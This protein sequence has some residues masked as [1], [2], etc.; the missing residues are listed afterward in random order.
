MARLGEAAR[1]NCLPCQDRQTNIP[2]AVTVLRV[3]ASKRTRL[4]PLMKPRAI[5]RGRRRESTR[6]D[7]LILMGNLVAEEGLELPTRGL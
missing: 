6:R 7:R 1:A 5:S 3:T 4:K 2:P